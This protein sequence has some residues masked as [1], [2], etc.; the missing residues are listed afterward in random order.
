[1]N[2]RPFLCSHEYANSAHVLLRS[3]RSNRSECSNRSIIRIT[4]KSCCVGRPPEPG[5]AHDSPL[6]VCY[7]VERGTWKSTPVELVVQQV[8]NDLLL[9]DPIPFLL[10]HREKP[11][12]PDEMCR[13]HDDEAAVSAA[14]A[15]LDLWHP[16][17]IAFNQQGCV[18]RRIVREA[19][20]QQLLQAGCVAS[21]P[22]RDDRLEVLALR[23]QILQAAAQHLLLH[24]GRQLIESVDL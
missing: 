1:Q 18:C 7:V 5:R 16:V 4:R 8:L 15:R 19:R 23:I 11:V 20:E 22:R 12:G 24:G 14:E 3:D 2:E 13:T 17:A 21:P 10:Q 6:P 9:G